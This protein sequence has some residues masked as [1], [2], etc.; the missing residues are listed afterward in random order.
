MRK[1]SNFCDYFVIASGTSTRHVNTIAQ[2]IEEDCSQEKIKPVRGSSCNDESG[3]M[4]LDFDSVIAHVF[5][6]P[7]R[8]F[9]ALE[10]LWRTP[11]RLETRQQNR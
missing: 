1:V 10:R 5:S 7:F 9:Y 3:W 4:V 6:K 2:A 8:D 11:K